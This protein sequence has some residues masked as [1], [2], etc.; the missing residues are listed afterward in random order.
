M[1]CSR[2]GGIMVYENFYS[3]SESFWGWRCIACGEIIDETIL[4]NRKNIER[5]MDRG[6]K[7]TMLIGFQGLLSEGGQKSGLG[8]RQTCQYSYR[9]LKID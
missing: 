6:N 9:V 5:T 7:N 4:E 1:K 3:P 8:H 2:C